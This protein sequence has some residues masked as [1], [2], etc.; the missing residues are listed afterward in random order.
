MRKTFKSNDD[1]FKFIN[2]Y[3]N[4][5]YVEKLIIKNSH[6]LLLYKNML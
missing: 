6:I 5:L 2:K 4:N 3:R 1:Y